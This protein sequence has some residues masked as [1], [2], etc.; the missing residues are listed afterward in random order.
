[1]RT[2]LLFLPCVLALLV[3]PAF[4]EDEPTK[5]PTSVFADQA[6]LDKH[7]AEACD[8]VEAIEGRAFES[9]PTIRVSTPKEVAA[10]LVKEFAVMPE[11]FIAAS[12]REALAKG[13]SRWLLAKYEPSTNI[14]HVVPGVIDDIEKAQPK[15]EKLGI[16]HLRALL[17][18]EAAHA[19]DFPRYDFMAVRAKLEDNDAQQALNA[20]VEGHAQ[21]VAEQAA[22]RWKIMPAFE[23]LTAAIIGSPD[24]EGT[25]EQKAIRAAQLSQIRFAY[26]QGHAFF[27]A[28]AK[29]GGSEA[30]ERAM[31]EPPTSSKMIEQ[32][33]LWLDPSKARA[34]ADLKPIV[35][36]LM[37]L[38]PKKG[39]VGQDVRVLSAALQKQSLRLPED[40]RGEW[41]QGFRD[42]HSWQSMDP[43][44]GARV[45]AVLLHFETPADAT[46][47]VTLDKVIVENAKGQPG[48]S[49]KT[50]ALKDGVGP[51]DGLPGFYMERVI[52]YMG[53]D[54]NARQVVTNHGTF[55][56]EMMV[57][58]APQ[59]ERAHLDQALV[60][61]IAWIDDPKAAAALPALETPMPKKDEPAKDAEKKDG[62]K[63]KELEPAGSGG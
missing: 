36:S 5:E 3:A 30:V 45:V 10:A 62:E 13:L 19:M 14:I 43:T 56:L 57:L 16:D 2:A 38:A 44:T 51:E 21:F 63:K 33:E 15:L 29:A 25:D 8:V 26:D 39:W 17:A 31:R 4:A 1:M 27:R 60:R 59:I 20:I 7:L 22:K 12:Q 54:I 46:R 23:R 32:P 37:W 52:T 61:L 50:I 34:A 9:R 41:L 49:M 55:A 53:H 6:L 28:V 24:D 18:H 11:S 58:N 35:R 48:M 42:A 47:F 40:R